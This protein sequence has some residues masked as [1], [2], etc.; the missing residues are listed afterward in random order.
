MERALL[1]N[2]TDLH[3]VPDVHFRENNPPPEFDDE[4]QPQ[5]PWLLKNESNGRS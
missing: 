3:T 5:G 4:A 1:R 2:H